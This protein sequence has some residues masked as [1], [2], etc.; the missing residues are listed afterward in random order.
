MVIAHLTSVHPRFD[1]RIYHMMC[2]SLRKL[3]DVHIICADGLGEQNIDGINIIDVGKSTNRF[4]RIWFSVNKIYQ[5]ANL[6]DADIY[7]IHDPEL[8]R[9]GYKLI[10]KGKK[11]IFDS[12]ED[13]GAT[14][15]N[16]P[17]LNSTLRK[18][19]YRIYNAYEKYM[20]KKFSALI[21]PTPFIKKKLNQINPFTE[22]ICNYP[23]SDNLK[24]EYR[25]KEFEKFEVCFVGGISHQRGVKELIKALE[26]TKNKVYLNLVGDFISEQYEKELRAEKGWKY[27]NYFGYID[28]RIKLKEIYQKSIIGIVTLLPNLNDINSLPIKMFEYMESQLPIIASDFDY[29]KEIFSEI[30]CGVNVNPNSPKDIAKAIDDLIDNPIKRNEMGENGYKAIINKYNWSIEEKKLLT[31]YKDLLQ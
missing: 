9:V 25:K 22:K 7:H 13:V 30:K 20:L 19:I 28:D 1:I 11:V 16:K 3:G 8:I 10:K 29:F 23:I 26:L 15:L 27:V 17:Y 5:K 14:I 4:S 31:L 2:K 21:A 12:H 18:L 24:T 6:M